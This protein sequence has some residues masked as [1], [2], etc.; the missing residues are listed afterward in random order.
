[1]VA[2][3]QALTDLSPTIHG[4]TDLLQQSQKQ[5]TKSDESALSIVPSRMSSRLSLSTVQTGDRDSVRSSA[6]LEYRRFSFE[7][8]LFTARV[9]KRNYRTSK[10]QG[11]R[12]QNP[13]DDVEAVEPQKGNPKSS[14]LANSSVLD[15]ELMVT[16]G[17]VPTDQE[18]GDFIEACRKGDKDKVSKVLKTSI[19]YGGT[20]A[21]YLLLSRK[22]DLVHLCPI[23]T[24]VYGG[25]LDV[26]E[27]LLEHAPLEHGENLGSLL[28]CRGTYVI[29]H[30]RRKRCVPPLHFAAYKGKL[31]MVQLLLR[32]GAPINAQ[33][34]HGL[35]AI[36]LAAKIG[37]IEVL[38]AL[39]AAGANVNCRDYKGRQPMHHLSEVERPEVIQYLA[40]KGAEI[41]GVSDTS[42]ITPL[43]FAC[44][45]GIDANAKALLS[46]GAL[47]TSPI[48]DTAVRI[49]SPGLVETLLI[50]MAN[51]EEGQS[52]MAT[53][54]HKYFTG[55]LGAWLLYEDDS[56]WARR[57]LRLLLEYTDLLLKDRNG[58]TVLHDLLD[59]QWKH[60]GE[61]FGSTFSENLFL[62]ILPDSKTGEKDE[63]RE[64]VRRKK[65]AL[66]ENQMRDDTDAF[67][68]SDQSPQS[69]QEKKTLSGS[70]KRSS[71]SASALS[72]QSSQYSQEK[73]SSFANREDGST[74][75]SVSSDTEQ[76]PAVS[77]SDALLPSEENLSIEAAIRRLTREACV[78]HRL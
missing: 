51:E 54:L 58:E 62:E 14:E 6:S 16:D 35:Q 68:F 15:Q 56:S 29:V 55:D 66:S 77:T 11:P 30:G 32:M 57:K 46:L 52:V 49:G 4:T 22:C 41:D 47:V 23:H 24:T 27:I 65:E 69:S 3:C 60:V 61:L 72:D 34:N 71:T 18:Y 21:P 53:Y 42:Q 50:S 73:T 7:N 10:Y 63:V 45:N 13:D 76:S 78:F 75:V 28:F 26:M 44:K 74:G 48:F 31:P 33:S 12:K 38:A 25:H 70:R 43:G 17:D 37:S 64:F 8:D 40:E 19:I 2:E 1:M 5:F 9:Y 39:I 36:H 20:M 67:V 59:A